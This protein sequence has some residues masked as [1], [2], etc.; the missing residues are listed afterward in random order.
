MNVVPIG[1]CIFEILC[2]SDCSRAEDCRI[3]DL[4]DQFFVKDDSA[5]VEVLIQVKSIDG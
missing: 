1:G 2:S 3:V 5:D 4:G